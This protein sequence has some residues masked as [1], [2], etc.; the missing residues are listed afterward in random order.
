MSITNFTLKQLRQIEQTAD[1]AGINLMQRAARS[2]ADWANHHYPTSSH[3]LIAVGTGN[4]GGDALWAG[5]NLHSRD[6]QIT[7]FIPEQVSSPAAIKALELCHI[8]KLPIITHLDQLTP[9]PMLIIDGLFGIGLNR[10]L[11]NNWQQVIKQ[12]NVLNLPIL[13]LDTPSGLDAYTGTIYG[14]AITATTTLTFLGDKP[15][16]HTEQGK[17][18]AGNVIVDILD[19]PKNMIP[20]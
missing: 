5:L 2:T 16:L 8:N 14:A 7:L 19:L 18:L 10:P 17:K 9:Q 20:T 12:L 3:I 13:A 1:K 6:Y 15:A 4:N 11:S